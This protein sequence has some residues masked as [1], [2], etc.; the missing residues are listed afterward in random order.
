MV[1]MDVFTRRV[2]GFGVAAANLDGALVCR[3]F[4]RAISGQTTPK[5]LSSDSDPLFCFHRWLA[6]LRILE[7]Q[8]IKAIPCTPRSH[9]F[10]ERL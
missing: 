7:I 3:M 2:I 8:Q 6:N 4:N 9:A 1:V 10:V 5:Y